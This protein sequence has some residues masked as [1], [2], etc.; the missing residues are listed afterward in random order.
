[1]ER[2]VSIPLLKCM[3][4]LGYEISNQIGPQW[5]TPFASVETNRFCFCFHKLAKLFS[6]LEN[7]PMTGTGKPERLRGNLQGYW[8]RRITKAD[9]LVYRIDGDAVIVVVVSAKSHYGE[10]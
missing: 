3:N 9:R 1:M 5:Q 2:V 6:E 10:K 8:S 7:H 4:S